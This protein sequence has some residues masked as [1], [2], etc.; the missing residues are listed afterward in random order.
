MI[1][2]N[3]DFRSGV[4]LFFILFDMWTGTEAAEPAHESLVGTGLIH[5][6]N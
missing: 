2:Q 6:A 1:A 5:L 4:F 3:V